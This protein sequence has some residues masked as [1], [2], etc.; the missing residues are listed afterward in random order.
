MHSTTIAIDLAKS[1]FEVG[2]SDRPGHICA[3]HRL[4]RKQLSVFVANQEPATIVM[5]ACSS[6]H[7]WARQFQGPVARRITG[8]GS[9]RPLVTT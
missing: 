7:H 9:F 2:V 3:Q 8:R 6:S 1:I 4:S 5:E